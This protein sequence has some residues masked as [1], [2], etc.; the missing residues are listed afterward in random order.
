[1]T[2]IVSFHS[3]LLGMSYPFL[4]Q[5]SPGLLGAPIVSTYDLFIFDSIFERVLEISIYLFDRKDLH[6]DFTAKLMY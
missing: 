1:M 4:D 2:C 3:S 6:G 5:D